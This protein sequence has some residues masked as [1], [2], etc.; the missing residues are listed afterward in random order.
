MVSGEDEDAGVWLTGWRCSGRDRPTL[1]H[2]FEAAEAADRFHEFVGSVADADGCSR[3][4]RANL[5]CKPLPPVR[6]LDRGLRV[7]RLRRGLRVLLRL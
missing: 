4:A 5:G 1:D 7:R 3:I 6:L 2:G